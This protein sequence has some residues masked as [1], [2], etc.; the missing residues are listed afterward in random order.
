VNSI[1]AELLKQGGTILTSKIREDI[2]TV[3]ETETIPE[4]WKTPILCPIFKKGD[5]PKIENYKGIL[6]LDTS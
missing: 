4:G 1:V 3:W 5:P 2:K 6:L